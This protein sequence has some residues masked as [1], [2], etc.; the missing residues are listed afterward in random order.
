MNTI[1]NGGNG[2]EEST[3]YKIDKSTINN[4]KDIIINELMK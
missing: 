4:N 2:D 1:I 3:N